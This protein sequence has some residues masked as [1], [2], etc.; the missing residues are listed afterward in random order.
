MDTYTLLRFVHVLG[1]ILLGAG[2]CAVFISELRAYLTDDVHAFAEA[3]R[4]TAVFYDGLTLPGAA[5][6]ALSGV[7]LMVE[8]GYGFFEHPWLTGMWGLFLF[9]FVEGN[10][11]TRLQFR[12]TLRKSLAARADGRLTEAVRREA[13][14]LLG[15]ITHFLD[16]PLFGVIVY[17]GVV[18]P[19]TWT[20]VGVAIIIAL[21]VAALLT[22]L[23]PR[24]KPRSV[25]LSRSA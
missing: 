3:G 14:T 15:Q 24:L 5:L 10:T 25:H 1:F 22:A 16:L 7:L 18:R 9:E 19:Q 13:R 20:E 17:C 4:Y 23:V 21:A 6:V 8:L 12:R 11:V 2:L